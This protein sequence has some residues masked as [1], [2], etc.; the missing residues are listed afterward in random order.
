MAPVKLHHVS[1]ERV[2]LLLLNICFVQAKAIY[3]ILLLF[4]Q[5]EQNFHA[6]SVVLWQ[7]HGIIIYVPND[8][9]YSNGSSPKDYC[10]QEID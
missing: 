9:S 8:T 3:I 10:Y 2:F 4:L 1:V 7:Y 5:Y 6:V